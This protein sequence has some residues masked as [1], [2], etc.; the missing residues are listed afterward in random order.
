MIILGH[1][2]HFL[3]TLCKLSL[4]LSLSLSLWVS[5]SVG[6]WRFCVCCCMENFSCTRFTCLWFWLLIDHL[7]FEFLWLFVTMYMGFKN[8][9]FPCLQNDVFFFF[10]ENSKWCLWLPKIAGKRRRSQFF[11]MLKHFKKLLLVYFIFYICFKYK[12]TL[13]GGPSSCIYGWSRWKVENFPI[14]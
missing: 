9:V 2:S 8:V 13:I 14:R 6:F 3:V 5:E 12:I 10:F 1:S 11:L 7:C 4:S